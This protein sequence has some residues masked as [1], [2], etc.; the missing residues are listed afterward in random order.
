MAETETATAAAT[1]AGTAP[2]PA[3]E[4]ATSRPTRPDENVFKEELAKAEKAHKAAMDRLVCF[5]ACHCCLLASIGL[6]S[7]QVR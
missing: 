7:C 4:K 3:T 1:A 6:T 2:A 5:E